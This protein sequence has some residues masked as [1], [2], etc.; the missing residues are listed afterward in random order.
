MRSGLIYLGLVAVVAAI[1]VVLLLWFPEKPGQQNAVLACVVIGSAVIGVVGQMLATRRPQ[2]TCLVASGAVN[3]YWHQH[4]RP[5][6]T[7][8]FGAIIGDCLRFECT[9]AHEGVQLEGRVQQLRQVFGGFWRWGTVVTADGSTK[10]S[11]I[12][13]GQPNERLK[14]EIYVPLPRLECGRVR[15]QLRGKTTGGRWKYAPPIEIDKGKIDFGLPTPPE[16]TAAGSEAS[17]EPT[18]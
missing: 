2:L 3:V 16:P 8:V 12:G 4:T 6:G 9:D 18:D 7:R 10:A 11:H 17:Q 14:L 15:L 5:D 1:V 13:R